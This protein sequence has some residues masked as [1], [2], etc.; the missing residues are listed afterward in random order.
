MKYLSWNEVKITDFS[1]EYVREMYEKGYVFTR[2]GRG[3]MQQTRS[4]RIDLN[5]FEPS[6]EN[7][8][9]LKRTDQISLKGYE[10]PFKDYDFRV[11][12]LAKDFYD[13]RFGAGI[14]SVQKIKEMMTDAT[15]S[16]FNSLLAYVKD[17]R[18]SP[19]GYAICYTNKLIRHY[20]YPFYDAT[21]AP[22]DMGLGMMIR[23]ISVSKELGHRYFYIGSLQ[24]PADT[25]K[26]Q[27]SGLEWFD[28]GPAGTG[29]W[30]QDLD[31]VKKILASAKMTE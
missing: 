16:N 30:R 28:G 19:L 3:I 1:D 22:K 7:R 9:I 31:A 6:S 21:A 27:F 12:K 26:L 11:G 25:Y 2:L 29:G 20:S 14:M 23:A 15:R 17:D 8:R 13:S 5:T 10:L 18:S 4:V 24:R